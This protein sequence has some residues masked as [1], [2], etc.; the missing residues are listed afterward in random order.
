M[1]SKDDVKDI[2]DLGFFLRCHIQKDLADHGFNMTGFTTRLSGIQGGIQNQAWTLSLLM[3][4]DEYITPQQFFQIKDSSASDFR[5]CESRIT[6]ETHPDLIRVNT[7]PATYIRSEKNVMAERWFIIQNNVQRFNREDAY[8]IDWQLMM[9]KSIGWSPMYHRM[10]KLNPENFP[11]LWERITMERAA[12][13]LQGINP[14]IPHPAFDDKPVPVYQWCL[15]ELTTR[16]QI[17][18]DSII[19][20]FEAKTQLATEIA[21]KALMKT[22]LCK[23]QLT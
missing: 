8:S 7:N 16:D 12:E 23:K 14:S 11:R 4:C 17:I 6:D 22:N 1:I 9:F 3:R 2:E 15:P 5:L 13:R 20:F 19:E 18:N 21:Q 10:I